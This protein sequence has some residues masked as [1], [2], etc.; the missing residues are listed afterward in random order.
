[1]T[2]KDDKVGMIV[3]FLDASKQTMPAPTAVSLTCVLCNPN[4]DGDGMMEPAEVK[5]LIAKITSIPEADIP[6][7]HHEARPTIV[8]LIDKHR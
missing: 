5:V 1:M 7:D 3:R 4:I 2:T 6:D 8:S